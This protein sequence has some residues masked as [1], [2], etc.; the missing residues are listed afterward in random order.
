MKHKVTVNLGGKVHHRG[1]LTPLC[2]SSYPSSNLWGVKQA[3]SGY[4]RSF[5]DIVAVKFPKAC[6]YGKNSPLSDWD[7]NFATSGGI[8]AGIA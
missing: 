6:T 5:R 2:P 7:P 8:G 3:R 1:E 4:F